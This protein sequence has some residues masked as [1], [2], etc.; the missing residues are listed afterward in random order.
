MTTDLKT[1]SQNKKTRT[2]ALP[3]TS[4][5]TAWHA[6]FADYGTI[7]SPMELQTLT[8]HDQHR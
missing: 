2:K 3:Y 4:A 8:I 7:I 6:T 1:I 5:H